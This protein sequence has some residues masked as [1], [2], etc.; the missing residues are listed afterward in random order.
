MRWSTIPILYIFLRWFWT[1]AKRQRFYDHDRTH[2]VDEYVCSSR[3]RYLASAGALASAGVSGC[4]GGGGG[5]AVSVGYLPVYPDLQWFVMDDQGYL[6]NVDREINS[7][8]FQNGTPMVRAFG[9]GDID[10]ALLGIV[11]A[12]N[13]IDRGIN[14]S[15]TAANITEPNALV[16]HEEFITRWEET[17]DARAFEGW[18]AENGQFEFGTFPQGSTPDVLLRF[19]LRERVGVDPTSVARIT[20]LGG[21]NPLFQAIASGEVDGGSVLEPVLTR[22]QQEDTPIELFKPAGEIMPGQPGA[23]VMMTDELRDSPFAVEF[24]EQHVRATEFITEE[25][26]ATA[27]IVEDGIG[28]PEEMARRALDGPI[29]NFTS[30]PR[31]I[32][33]GTETFAAFINDLGQTDRELTVSEIFDYDSYDSV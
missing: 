16:A 23:V 12:L 29:S 15:V 6:E 30:D 27:R 22:V 33:S 26:A 13:V 31:A 11:P 8:E 3:R 18:A 19:W 1:L 4:L 17:G 32:E 25:P 14:A 21:A 2:T 10:A 7:R 20:E 9:S 28:I 5:D 24:L